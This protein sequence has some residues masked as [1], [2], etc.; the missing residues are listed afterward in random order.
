MGAS[1]HLR[2]KSIRGIWNHGKFSSVSC[3]SILNRFPEVHLSLR[4]CVINTTCAWL[5]RQNS[6][7]QRFVC[8]IF[9]QNNA[10]KSTKNELLRVLSVF[11]VGMCNSFESAEERLFITSNGRVD[12]HFY[13]RFSLY[14][15]HWEPL[16]RLGCFENWI[17]NWN[18]FVSSAETGALL[19]R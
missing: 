6:H 5:I 9:T 7:L 16:G 10:S 14:K 8:V 15:V 13:R 17:I 3:S 19:H 12:F 18:S 4:E 11:L 2:G 1:M